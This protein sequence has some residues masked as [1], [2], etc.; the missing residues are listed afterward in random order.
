MDRGKIKHGFLKKSIKWC[1]KKKTK[2]N[3]IAELLGT[4]V[5]WFLATSSQPYQGFSCRWLK[6]DSI[7]DRMLLLNHCWVLIVS[8]NGYPFIRQSMKL[9]VILATKD[10]LAC[11]LGQ[12][13][14]NNMES[15]TKKLSN[16]CFMCKQPESFFYINIYFSNRFLI[17]LIMEN[18]PNFKMRNYLLVWRKPDNFCFFSWW[19]NKNANES[20][21]TTAV[22]RLRDWGGPGVY[23][24]NPAAIPVCNTRGTKESI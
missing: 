24:S 17:Q 12:T 4:S 3:S 9:P 19:N 21:L 8:K 7:K 2:Q 18:I 13:F 5:N 11:K 15:K 10:K 14:S 23:F 1:K 20:L 6:T 16:W 22:A